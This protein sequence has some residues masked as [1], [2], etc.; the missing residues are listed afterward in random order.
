MKDLR[1]GLF[2]ELKVVILDVLSDNRVWKRKDIIDKID[3]GNNKAVLNIRTD[4]FP[5]GFER[6]P[7]YVS[8][9]LKELKSEGKII[10]VSRGYWKSI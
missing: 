1:S 4:N 8:A 9:A 2:K 5:C 10:N 7:R 6:F 3:Q